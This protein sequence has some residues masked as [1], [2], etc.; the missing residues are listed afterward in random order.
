MLIGFFDAV[1]RDPKVLMGDILKFIGVSDKVKKRTLHK[2]VNPSLGV[3]MP[4]HFREYLTEKYRN[5]IE[6]LAQCYG[7]YALDWYAGLNEEAE[8]IAGNTKKHA[9]TIQ[10]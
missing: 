9:A 4:A 6:A 2:I 7:N 1:F 8:V 10:P 5:D 3:K